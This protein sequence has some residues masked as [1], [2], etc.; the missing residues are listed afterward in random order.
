MRAPAD[1]PPELQAE[2]AQWEPEQRLTSQAWEP[3]SGKAPGALQDVG[4]GA[5][6][7]ADVLIG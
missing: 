7:S 1:M 4:L 2:L 5:T 3:A 6:Q